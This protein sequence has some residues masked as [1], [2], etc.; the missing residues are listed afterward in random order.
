MADND[1]E[2]MRDI[3]NYVTFDTLVFEKHPIVKSLEDSGILSLDTDFDIFSEYREM[4]QAKHTFDDGAWISVIGGGKTYSDL[5]ANVYEVYS[6]ILESPVSMDI[7][8]I[9][10]HLKELQGIE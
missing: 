1:F 4:I 5:D 8:E 7:G 9:N 3:P 2:W 6:S 10:E